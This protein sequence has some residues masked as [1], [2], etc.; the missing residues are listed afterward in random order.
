[1]SMLEGLTVI[2]ASG[3]GPVPFCG[4][5][6]REMGARVL[7]VSA[8]AATLVPSKADVLNRDK[9]LVPLDLKTEDG[10]RGFLD[11]ID[12]ADALVEGFRPGVMERLGLGPEVCQAR[13][14]E[15]VYGRMTGYGQNGPLAHL[16][17][18]DINF[19]ALSG[20]L[21]LVGQKDGPPIPP[22]NIAADFGGGAMFMAVSVLGAI[23]E[24]ERTGRGRILDISMTEA[25]SKLI[26][27]LYGRYLTDPDQNLRGANMV[28]G[29]APFYTTYRTADGKYLAVGAI[30]QRF[31]DV[32]AQALDL[33]AG[34]AAARMDKSTWPALRD[35]MAVAFARRTR[36]DWVAQLGGTDAC[37][38]PVLDLD[39]AAQH[40]Q[41]VS[42]GS[43]DL[44][45][46]GPVPAAVV[47]GD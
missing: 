24:S 41:A 42:R 37:L 5:V 29:G 6:L 40:E 46:G 19:A 3:H 12:E 11:L 22:L 35:A 39:E 36:D 14:P 38:S 31:F 1:M 20:V 47:R 45:Q 2:E 21:H 28:D 23:R 30:E 4:M 44:S 15:L 10:R 17:G 25:A 43:F 13:R 7:R 9:T 16:P 33:P 26:T 18:H 34:L 27:S 32:L 8:P